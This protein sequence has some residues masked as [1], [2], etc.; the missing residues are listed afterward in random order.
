MLSCLA[1]LAVERDCGR[2]EWWV[3]DWNE[4]AIKFYE[5][6]GAD[7]MDEWTTYRVSGDQLKELSKEFDSTE[8]LHP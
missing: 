2:L 1:R 5:T 7:A 4:P 8:N 3:L 6:L